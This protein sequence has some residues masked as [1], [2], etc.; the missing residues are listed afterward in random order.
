MLGRTWIRRMVCSKLLEST[1]EEQYF[2]HRFEKDFTNECGCWAWVKLTCCSTAQCPRE[3]CDGSQAFFYQVQIRSA[4]E[5]MTTFYK[6]C[7][8]GKGCLCFDVNR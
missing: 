4:D 6:V 8:S 7:S 1:P 5:P 2:V 3:G